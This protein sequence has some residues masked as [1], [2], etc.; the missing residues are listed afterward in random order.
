MMRGGKGREV[1]CWDGRE[2]RMRMGGW[3][4]HPERMKGCMRGG[5]GI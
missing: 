2:V 4:G 1:Q 3:E 5:K